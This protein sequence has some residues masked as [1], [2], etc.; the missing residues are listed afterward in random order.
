LILFAQ[1]IPYRL[2]RLDKG[3]NN[4]MKALMNKKEKT[5]NNSK[6]LQ[7]KFKYYLYNPL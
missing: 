4:R 3:Y 1:T 2:I 5:I 7:S 6:S